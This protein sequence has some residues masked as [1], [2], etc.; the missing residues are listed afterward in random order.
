MPTTCNA[1]GAGNWPNELCKYFRGA[2]MVI[3]PD[4][5]PQSTNPKDAGTPVPSGW[6]APNLPV[7]TTPEMWRQCSPMSPPMCASFYE[8]PGHKD[9]SDWFNAGGTVERLNELIENKVD[10][11]DR[12]SGADR[13]RSQHVRDGLDLRRYLNGTIRTRASSMIAARP[14][15]VSR[16]CLFPTPPRVP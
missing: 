15:G 14:P 12:I 11:M 3:L 16:Q 10:P 13:Q 2:D 1:G 8:F 9:V 6:A 4:N 7:K 5:D